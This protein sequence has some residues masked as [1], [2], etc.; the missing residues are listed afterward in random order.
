MQFIPPP[1]LKCTK[2]DQQVWSQQRRAEYDRW[3][4]CH[5]QKYCMVGA[6]GAFLR[7]A[8]WAKNALISSCFTT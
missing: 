1:T 3:H 6:E 4:P 2:S 5:L 8:S 7:D